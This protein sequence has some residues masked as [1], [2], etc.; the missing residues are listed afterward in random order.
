M[1]ISVT[2]VKPKGIIGWLVFLIFTTP[3]SLRAKK[4]KGLLLCDYNSWNGYR[5][6][7]T[8]WETKEHMLSFRA[9]PA[10][11]RAMKRISQIGTGKVFGYEVDVCPTRE[12]V[13]AELDIN[14]REF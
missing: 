5:H 12:E 2:G 4:A 13:F 11:E 7:L 6:T 14:G 1:Y 3:A 8:A 9:L 10:H